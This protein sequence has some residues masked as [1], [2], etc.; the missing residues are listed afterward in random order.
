MRVWEVLALGK[1]KANEAAWRDAKKL[2]RLSGRQ[3]AMARAL[4]MN[5]KKLP[6]P[7][8]SPQQRWKLPLGTFIEECYRERFGRAPESDESRQACDNRPH[9]VDALE[10]ARARTGQVE[11]LVCYLLN[12]AEDLQR[13]LVQGKIAPEVLARVCR[14]FREIA[15]ALEAGTFI[16]EMPEIPVPPAPRSARSGLGDRPEHPFDGDDE[17]PF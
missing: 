6:G 13:W 3:V 16:P 10:M 11:S 8:P 17:I 15:N 5:P 1:G 12:L 7:R 14:E 4:G 9:T 2:C